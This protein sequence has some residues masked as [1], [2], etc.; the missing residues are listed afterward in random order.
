MD[1]QLGILD[2]RDFLH[3]ADAQQREIVC[4]Q[5]HIQMNRY[6]THDSCVTNTDV[7]C[8]EDSNT[9]L[10]QIELHLYACSIGP[11]VRFIF[12]FIFWKTLWRQ[13]RPILIF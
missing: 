6:T 3:D 7:F 10:E 13:L 11:I 9:I 5:H 1:G 8:I 4:H 2:F 12:I